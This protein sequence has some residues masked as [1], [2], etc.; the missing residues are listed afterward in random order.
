MLGYLE[1]GKLQLEEIH[2]FANGANKKDGVLCWDLDYLF[3]EIKTGMKKCKEIGKVPDSVGIDTWG[4]DFVLLNQK[5]EIIGNT[6]CY[7]DERTSDMPREVFQIINEEELYARTGIQKQP[8]N[9]I[10]QLMALSRSKELTEAESML[11]IPDYF[12]F[13][14]SGVKRQEYT[15]ATTTQL[16]NPET[17]D[18][19]YDLIKMLGYPRKIF[20]K[21]E[22]PGTTLGNLTKEIRKEIGYSCK[23]ILPATHDT[24]SAVLSVPTD[25]MDTVYISSGT[26]SLM[27]VER[28][29]ADCSQ[30][31]QIRN[32]TNEGGYHYRFR[33]LKN[34]MG[35]WMIQ[36]VRK[37]IGAE[38]SF[39]QICDLAQLSTI[40][41]L[42]DCNDNRFLAPESMTETV[43]QVCRE[44]GEQVPET[45]GEVASVI[46]HSLAKC[47]NDT[48]QEIEQMTKVHYTGIH[49]VGGGANA[50]YLNKLTSHYTGRTVYAGPT[51]ATAIGNLMVQMLTAKE[52]DSLNAARKCV[53]DSFDIK[54]FQP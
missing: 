21:I 37:E 5:N 33:Y 50:D 10:Y 53:Y 1:D 27:G 6:V 38:Y 9:T 20:Q 26:W 47:Y 34:I 17:K 13:L 8:F 12:N 25:S 39:A 52:L 45:L 51:E 3:Q 16:I 2:R 43:K 31:S 48:V 36:S 11:M 30:Q 46:Y 7:R 4:V 54:C 24:G 14:L 22:V 32:F 18:W 42:V 35:L 44:N 23:V 15:N 41:S 40:Q 19:D 28:M 29:Q 49:V